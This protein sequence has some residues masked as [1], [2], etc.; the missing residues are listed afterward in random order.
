MKTYIHA[1]LSKEDRAMLEE[2]KRSTG[3]SES[4]LLR[5]GLRLVRRELEKQGTALQLAGTSA[6]KFVGGAKDL[7]RNKRHLAEFGR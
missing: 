3:H 1:R 5:R 7:A 4:A 2:L 6:G